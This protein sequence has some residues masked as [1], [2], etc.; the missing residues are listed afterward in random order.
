MAPALRCRLPGSFER[1]EGTDQ[2]AELA[3]VIIAH[4]NPHQLG[5]LVATLGA[6][7]TFVHLDSGL[8]SVDRQQLTFAAGPAALL[9]SHRSAW[10]SWGIVAGILEGF[11]AALAD[12]SL[13]HVCVLTGQDYPL[14][15]VAYMESLLPEDISFTRSV[16]LPLSFYGRDG[17]L[18]RIQGLNWRVMGGRRLHVPVR[19]SIPEGLVPCASSPWSIY[20]RKHIFSLLDYADL[21]GRWWS[22]VWIPDEHFFASVLGTRHRAELLDFNPLYTEWTPG[23]PHPRTFASS[24]IPRL[25]QIRDR[26]VSNPPGRKWFARKFDDEDGDLLDQLSGELGRMPLTGQPL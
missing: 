8:H 17:G 10:A 22:H 11:N 20:A 24:D 5:R 13:T 12:S 23:I 14:V 3:F 7:R 25:V 1:S 21:H 19:R 9:P 16:P 2:L 6:E 15:P 4:R 26:Y 18:D